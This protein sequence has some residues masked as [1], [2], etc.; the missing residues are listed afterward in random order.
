MKDGKVF[1]KTI[2]KGNGNKKSIQSS[3]QKNRKIY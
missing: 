2:P 1:Q 3:M